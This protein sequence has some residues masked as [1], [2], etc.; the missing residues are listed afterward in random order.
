MATQNKVLILKGAKYTPCCIIVYYLYSFIAKTV[1][2]YRKYGAQKKIVIIIIINII[3][4]ICLLFEIDYNNM[5]Y[6]M[7]QVMCMEVGRACYVLV[8]VNYCI[9]LFMYCN[10]LL[11][12]RF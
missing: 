6:N 11:N 9:I 2:Y 3:S 4:S 7:S 5:V 1:I 8:L 10:K 12:L